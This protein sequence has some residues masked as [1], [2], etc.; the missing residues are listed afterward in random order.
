M[1]WKIQNYEGKDDSS[2][3]TEESSCH[4][5][6]WE[7]CGVGFYSEHI[8]FEMPI[9]HYRLDVEQAVDICL[10][11]RARDRSFGILKIEI[12]FKALDG[13]RSSSK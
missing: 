2:E 9:V 11:F 13:M 5:P 3:Q 10:K 7:G 6:T 1:V 8:T 12:A 4:L